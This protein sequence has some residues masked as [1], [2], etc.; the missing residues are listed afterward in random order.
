MN[1]AIIP[2][3]GGSKRIL[4]KNIREFAGKPLIAYSIEAAKHSKCFERVIVSTDCEEIAAVAK[5]YGADVPFMRPT[6]LADDYTGTTA[7]TRHAIKTMQ[8]LGFEFEYSCCIYA[9]APLLHFTYL[10]EGLSILKN[11]P[12]KS[13]SFS[14]TSF[15][16]PIQRAITVSE[17]GVDVLFPE[18]IK[19]RSQDLIETYHDAGQFYWGRSNAYL[20]GKKSMFSHASTPV[21]LPRHLVQDIDTI[22]DWERAELM[23]K[24]Y[25][26]QGSADK[27]I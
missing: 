24:A 27:L 13:F 7:V 2:A 1:L 8:S 25:V 6:E 21:I 14:A 12:H 10:R 11:S 3:R 4:R 18:H 23:Y 9:T 16:F 5:Q 26:Q 17:Q 20:E 22:E 19:K 15:A